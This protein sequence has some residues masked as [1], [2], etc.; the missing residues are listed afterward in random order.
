M[1]GD[2]VEPEMPTPWFHKE[3]L[4]FESAYDMVDAVRSEWIAL[5][6]PLFFFVQDVTITGGLPG[7]R[8]PVLKKIQ[9]SQRKCFIN[10]LFCD[11]VYSDGILGFANDSNA[12]VSRVVLPGT[13]AEQCD[14][15][16]V[17]VDLRVKQ[18]LQSLGI[19]GSDLIAL[20]LT[21]CGGSLLMAMTNSDY[22]TPTFIASKGFDIDL[23]VTTT[24]S[25]EVVSSFRKL[26]LARSARTATSKK[27]GFC[28]DFT[29]T[30]GPDNAVVKIQIVDL[31]VRCSPLELVQS[32]DI[33]CCRIYFDNAAERVV[34]TEDAAYS[35]A[36]KVIPFERR[37]MGD[38]R[39]AQRVLKYC[40][41]TGFL[42]ATDPLTHALARFVQE[43]TERMIFMIGTER[44]DECMARVLKAFNMWTS[45]MPSS[46]VALLTRATL[47]LPL[48]ASLNAT[49]RNY[50]GAMKTALVP[51]V[52]HL[53]GGCG[54][55]HLDIIDRAP[56]LLA[57]MHGLFM[58]IQMEAELAALL[59]SSSSVRG[60]HVTSWE[61]AAAIR[62]GR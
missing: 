61:A 50:P 38:H 60:L 59:T 47:L 2:L 20:G 46:D 18:M 33:A 3:S 37:F 14:I 44:E 36:N 32:F 19:Y 43:I 34:L 10:R 48:N 27:R 6:K 55:P 11:Q 45:E 15:Y 52:R 21:L 35:F 8:D 24:T 4:Q 31:G 7:Y 13:P 9:S 53:T 39:Y 23:F 5:R 1:A 57:E 62:A 41:R 22:I 58:L 28:T 49:E 30:Y 25:N 51:H 42:L 17:G 12:A 16:P 29:V 56:S 40:R 26:L 54:R